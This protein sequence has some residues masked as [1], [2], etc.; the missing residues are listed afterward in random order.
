LLIANDPIKFANAIIGLLDDDIKL[1]AIGMSGRKYVEKHH[2]WMNITGQLE[3]VYQDA[4]ENQN[5]SISL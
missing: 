1:E 4:I 2:D 3:S 5:H